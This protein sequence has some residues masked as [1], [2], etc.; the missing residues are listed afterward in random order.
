MAKAV[1]TAVFISLCCEGPA[2]CVDLPDGGHL[3]R[4]AWQMSGYAHLE[5]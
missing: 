4:A 2:S 1:P 5:V 3:V